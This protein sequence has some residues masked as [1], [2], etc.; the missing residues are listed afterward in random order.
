[1][2]CFEVLVWRERWGKKCQNPILRD[3][4]I[5]YSKIVLKNHFLKKK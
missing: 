3:S 5:T 1:M 4:G 2:K